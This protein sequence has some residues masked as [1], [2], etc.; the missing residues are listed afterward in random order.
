MLFSL[1]V[2]FSGPFAAERSGHLGSSGVG[3]KGDTHQIRGGERAELDQMSV[4]DQL[5]S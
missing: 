5:V 3:T 4:S 2:G 1:D